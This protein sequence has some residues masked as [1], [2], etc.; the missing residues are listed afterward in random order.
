MNHL[1][2]AIPL[3]DFDTAC[4]MLNELNLQSIL[5][6]SS[7]E[8]TWSRWK[9]EFMDVMERCIPKTQVPDRRN[10]ATLVNKGD[11]QINEEEK[12]FL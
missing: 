6:D 12:L 8:I 2:V 10:L 9:Q 11:R 3:A 1:E 5:D 4:E 7:I